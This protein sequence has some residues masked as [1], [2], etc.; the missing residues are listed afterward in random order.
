[1]AHRHF[2]QT[3]LRQGAHRFLL[4]NHSRRLVLAES[5]ET[6]F[7][8]NAR[9]KGLLGR[10]AFAPGAVLAIAPSNAVH[11]FRMQF[12][13]DLL[14][15]SREGR[16]VKRVLGLKPGRIAAALRAFAVLEFAAGSAQVASTSIGDRL[17]L[18]DNSGGESS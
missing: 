15:I 4:V 6:A 3:L 7:D 14:C 5:I 12:P 9:R 10:R 8:S 11:T 17:A 1:V 13:I 16:V 2:F 18:R